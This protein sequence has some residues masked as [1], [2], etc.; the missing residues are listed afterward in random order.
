[1]LNCSV[2]AAALVGAGRWLLVVQV[3]IP[4][5]LTGLASPHRTKVRPHRDRSVTCS[6][7]ALSA[8]LSVA[9]R[10]AAA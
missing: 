7:R 3:P 9:R 4:D 2:A 8:A 5:D 1:M 6:Y 10:S